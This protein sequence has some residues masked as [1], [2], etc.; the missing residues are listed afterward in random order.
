[1][2]RKSLLKQMT[3]TFVVATMALACIPLSNAYAATAEVKGDYEKAVGEIVIP[4]YEDDGKKVD[5]KYLIL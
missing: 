4:R 3:K 5:Q 2:K 1:M